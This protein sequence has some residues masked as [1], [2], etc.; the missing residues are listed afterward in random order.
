MSNAANCQVIMSST[1]ENVTSAIGLP[2]VRHSSKGFGVG[3]QTRE[4]ALRLLEEKRL[5]FRWIFC[6]MGGPPVS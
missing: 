3:G 6:G 5:D 1:S 4:Q 2:S